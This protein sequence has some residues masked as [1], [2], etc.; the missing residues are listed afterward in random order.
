[1]TVARDL[2]DLRMA[3][4]YLPSLFLI[5]IDPNVPLLSA[6]Y[7]EIPWL[8]ILAFFSLL[9]AVYFHGLSRNVFGPGGPEENPMK[10]DKF[11]RGVQVALTGKGPHEEHPATLLGMMVNVSGQIGIIGFV[12]IIVWAISFIVW[13]VTIFFSLYVGITKFESLQTTVQLLLFAEIVWVL[14]WRVWSFYSPSYLM[15][16]DDFESS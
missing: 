13:T 6:R 5:I 9:A 10:Q 16:E 11:I 12:F 15:D 2:F 1:M 3:G 7:P 4:L 14:Q 8:P